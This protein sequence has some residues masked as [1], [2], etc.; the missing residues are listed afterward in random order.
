VSIRLPGISDDDNAVLGHLLEQ[1]EAKQRRNFLRASYYD[2]KRAIKQVGTVIPPQYYRLGIVLGWSAKA[3]DILARRCNLDSFVWPDGDLDSIGYR[4]VSDGN[5][6][7]TEVSSA[8][9]SSLIHGTSFLINTRGDAAVGEPESLIHVKDAFSATGDWNA[10]RRG[11]DNLLSITGRN[12]D[13]DPTSLALYLYGRTIVAEKDSSGWH[14]DV[15]EHPWGVPAEPMVY[16]PR[17]GPPVRPRGS[18][19]R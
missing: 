18:P 10:R 17:V 13:G 8:L 3:V 19:G 11:L 1:L 2:G 4:E 12:S 9:V 5:Q 6:L 14:V 16:K 7:G 15:T